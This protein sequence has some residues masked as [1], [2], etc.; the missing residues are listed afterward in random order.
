MRTIKLA[1]ITDDLTSATDGTACF[2][3]N[4]WKTSI[5]RPGWTLDHP[6]DILSI[7]IDSRTEPTEKAVRKIAERQTTLATAS[8]VVK[9]F[10]STLR[11]HVAAECYAALQMSGRRALVVVPAFP[12]AGRTTSN[13]VQLLHGVPVDQTE[14]RSDPLNPVLNSSVRDLF[15][16]VSNSVTCVKNGADVQKA[17]QKDASIVIVDAETEEQLDEVVRTLFADP[18]LAWA[19]STGLVRAISRTAFDTGVR[20]ETT[21]PCSVR[22]LVVVGSRSTVSRRQ[23]DMFVRHGGGSTVEITPSDDIRTHVRDIRQTM[24]TQYV[25]ITTPSSPIDP[26]QAS[27]LLGEVAARLILCK[28]AD[29][30]IATGGETAKHILE[31]TGVRA[32]DVIAELEPGVPCCLAKSHTDCFPIVTKAGGFG[33]DE[34]FVNAIRALSNAA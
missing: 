22:P 30:I 16:Q 10:D 19:G 18:K 29:G 5:L 32:I 25:S 27:S 7:D 4:A 17:L 8:H 31:M 33:S 28:A 23:L 24:T 13:G 11:G 26:Q 3:Q 14:F 15:K 6:T 9:Q 12:S 1:I 20:H 2:A 34:I 21:L